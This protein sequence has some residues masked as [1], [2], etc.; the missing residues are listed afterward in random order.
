[1]MLRGRILKE[2]FCPHPEMGLLFFMECQHCGAT[3]EWEEPRDP[4]ASRFKKM[5]E[6]DFIL[7]HCRCRKP[8]LARESGFHEWRR[9]LRQYAW[10][11]RNELHWRMV[12]RLRA[13]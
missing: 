1:M 12:D 5:M 9:A 13:G 4:S 2:S 7:H 11:H 8:P 10:R 3:L 6:D